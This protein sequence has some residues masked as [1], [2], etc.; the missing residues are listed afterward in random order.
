MLMPPSS[1][2]MVAPGMP[3]EGPYFDRR[4]MHGFSTPSMPPPPPPPQTQTPL[5]WPS[6]E[7][8][9]P[10]PATTAIPAK[11]PPRYNKP[12]GRVVPLQASYYYAP[13]S[14]SGMQGK[15]RLHSHQSSFSKEKD[16]SLRRAEDAQCE[17]KS[18]KSDFTDRA[19]LT[20][21]DRQY[22]M[23]SN[24]SAQ[25][26]EKHYPLRQQQDLGSPTWR[27]HKSHVSAQH[28]QCV[29]LLVQV[30]GALLER[31]TA[32]K[33]A[34]RE[35]KP[36]S[37]KGAIG[38][39][40][41]CPRADEVHRHTEAQQDEDASI[42]KGQL[43]ELQDVFA[44]LQ[45]EGAAMEPNRRRLVDAIMAFPQL[46]PLSAAGFS[47]LEESTSSCSDSKVF[48]DDKLTISRD[49]AAEVKA[50]MKALDFE[51]TRPI[52]LKL[53]APPSSSSPSSIRALSP[54]E[55]KKKNPTPSP[56]E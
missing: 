5:P 21:H 2:S 34:V 8:M 45:E 4:Q 14:Q 50:L 24:F 44:S 43:T 36:I 37:I 35:P 7:M 38:D 32:A 9:N 26:H 19:N 42:L 10:P 3:T 23:E 51:T 25:G 13:N 56:S 20:L 17:R 12:N 55:V 48:A 54:A 1:Q 11:E 52:T 6:Q 39:P 22:S 41:L 49:V 46:T 28:R 30:I 33:S 53:V 18:E 40:S 31:V 47:S 27:E 15:Y 29:N 16:E